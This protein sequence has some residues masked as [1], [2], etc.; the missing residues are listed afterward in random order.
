MARVSAALPRGYYRK[1]H[2]N[3]HCKSAQGSSRYWDKAYTLIELDP[4]QLSSD[5]SKYQQIDQYWI[6]INA[7]LDECGRQSTPSF[8]GL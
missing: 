2:P 4:L 8:L 7:I 6:K 1:E 3:E 5:A